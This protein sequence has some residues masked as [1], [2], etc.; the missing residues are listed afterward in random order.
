MDDVAIMTELIRATNEEPSVGQDSKPQGDGVQPSNT[1]DDPYSNHL[2][3]CS[4]SMLA[5]PPTR[6]RAGLAYIMLRAQIKAVAV[7]IADND[8]KYAA[9]KKQ[10]YQQA[11]SLRCLLDNLCL[12]AYISKGAGD[13][14]DDQ[15]NQYV[16]VSDLDEH[17]DSDK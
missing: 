16:S 1:K 7:T 10:H 14:S 8:E 17:D 3:S 12:A 5:E 9:Y 4:I 13:V 6:D 2:P 11:F 15:F